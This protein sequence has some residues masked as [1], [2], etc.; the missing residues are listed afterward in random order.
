MN[1]SEYWQMLKAK[2]SEENR[3]D[4]LAEDDAPRLTV[5]ELR[6]KYGG[7]KWGLKDA[8]RA[9]H[10]PAP[11]WDDVIAFMQANPSRLANLIKRADDQHPY[12]GEAS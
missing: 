7:E 3:R 10:E 1:Q 12:E 4:R 11:S 2:A 5:A 6:A 8:P 9:P